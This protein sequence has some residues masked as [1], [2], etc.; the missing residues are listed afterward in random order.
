MSF[1]PGKHSD[2][3]RELVEMLGAPG[4][5]LVLLEGE[6]GKARLHVESRLPESVHPAHFLM[7]AAVSATQGDL[8]LL[9]KSL[10]DA[11]KAFPRKE[12]H[13]EGSAEEM[14]SALYR[15]ACG[16]EDRGKPPA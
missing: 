1:G 2:L 10:M 6:R 11:M 15:E 16:Q 7:A 8:E 9:R 13:G 3:M 12:E 5:V 14:G 4:G